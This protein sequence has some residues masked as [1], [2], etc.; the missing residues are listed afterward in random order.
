MN[1]INGFIANI[2]PEEVVDREDYINKIIELLKNEDK[3]NVIIL[4]SESAVGKTSLVDKLLIDDAINYDKIR[5]KTH[6]INNS[7]KIKEWEYFENIFYE[8]CN[9]YK[10]T[11]DSFK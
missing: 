6:P 5:I 3:S 11:S 4:A 2:K 8:V 9:K 1:N 10:S 7:G